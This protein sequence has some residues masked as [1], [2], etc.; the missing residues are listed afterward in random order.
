MAHSASP[1]FGVWR[2]PPQRPVNL[3][4]LRWLPALFGEPCP[5]TVLQQISG[6]VAYLS[7][8]ARRQTTK[9]HGLTGVMPIHMGDDVPPVG[10][11]LCRVVCEP[12]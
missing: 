6:S 11:S 4:A 10:K 5:M 7:A 2:P 9:L 1:A 12:A 3:A 8:C